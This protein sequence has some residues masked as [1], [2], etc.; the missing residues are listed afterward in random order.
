MNKKFLEKTYLL[1]VED[2]RFYIGLYGIYPNNVKTET[3]EIEVESYEVFTS[4]NGRLR[5]EL[6]IIPNQ[7]INIEL[8]E[9]T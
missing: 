5:T 3:K 6:E 4:K 1:T 8:E 9:Y 7:D 2:K